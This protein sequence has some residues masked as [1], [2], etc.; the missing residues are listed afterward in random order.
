MTFIL[1]VPTDP[2]RFIQRQIEACNRLRQHIATANKRFNARR[3]FHN[4]IDDNG[5]V[6]IQI[7]PLRQDR[8]R[9]DRILNERNLLENRREQLRI[10]QLEINK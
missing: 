6:R 3:Y 2:A 1:K 4:Q 7:Q 10:R 8:T 9:Q 5:F